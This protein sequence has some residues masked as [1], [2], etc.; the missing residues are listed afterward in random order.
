MAAARARPQYRGWVQLRRAATELG[1]SA[2]AAH[3]GASAEVRVLA[4]EVGRQ[5]RLLDGVNLLAFRD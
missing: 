4:E 3:I 5:V 2:R 1:K